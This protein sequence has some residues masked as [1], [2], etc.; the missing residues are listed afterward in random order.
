MAGNF[1]A[2]SLK[3][4]LFPGLPTKT[5]E[6]GGQQVVVEL[7][8]TPAEQERGL[9]G[10]TAL[11]EGRG[12]L[13]DMG[14]DNEWP[15]WMKDMHFAIDIVWLAQ[16]GAIVYVAPNVA[17]ATYLQDPPQIFKPDRP[18]RYVLE[19]PAGYM[20]ASGIGVGERVGL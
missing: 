17:P 20:A 16:D 11:P 1:S 15:F 14:G 5:I 12:M 19:L 10:R 6:V 2:T 4:L 7:P 9:G 3:Y 18:A 8:I 13:F